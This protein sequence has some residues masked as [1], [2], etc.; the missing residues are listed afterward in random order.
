MVVLNKG[1]L[2][3]KQ[4]GITLVL[5]SLVMLFLLG[6]AAAGSTA[7]PAITFTVADDTIYE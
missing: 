7:A 5:I 3:R 4:Q 1:V 2:K 6:M